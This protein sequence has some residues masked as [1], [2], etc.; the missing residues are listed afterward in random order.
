MSSQ[1]IRVHS[2]WILI[3]PGVGEWTIGNVCLQRDCDTGGAMERDVGSS[4]M[5]ENI[6]S[7]I[8]IHKTTSH[9]FSFELFGSIWYSE[10]VAYDII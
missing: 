3:S 6:S 7:S 1:E 2:V 9:L 10:L 5:D 8:P 4:N